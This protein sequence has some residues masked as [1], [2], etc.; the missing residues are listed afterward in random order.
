MDICTL[1]STEMWA[2]AVPWKEREGPQD[3]G[4]ARCSLAAPKGTGL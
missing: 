4:E 2:S 3:I 1:S